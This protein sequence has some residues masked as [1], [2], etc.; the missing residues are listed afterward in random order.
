MRAIVVAVLATTLMGQQFYPFQ[1]DGDALSGAPDFSWLNKPLQPAD[2]VFVRDGHFYKLG[3][4]LVPDTED[5]ARIRF[6]GVNTTFGGN[7]PAEKDAVRIARRLRRLG[8]NLV[9]FHHMD[10]SPDVDP[11]SARSVLL[12]TG[13]YPTF[14]PVALERLRGFLRALKA[15]GIYANINLHVGYRFRPETDGVP[16]LPGAENLPTQSKPLHILYPRMVELQSDF[17]RELLRRLGVAGDPVLAMVETNNETSLLWHWQVNRLDEVLGGDYR[18]E[19]IRQ[20]NEYLSSRYGTTEALREAWSAGARSAGPELL[21]EP[22]RPLEVHSPADARLELQDDVAAVVVQRAGGPVILKK[23]GFSVEAAAAYSGEIEIRADLP[24]GESRTVYWDLKMDVEPWRTQAGRHLAVSNRWQQFTLPF[25]GAFTMDKVGRM[26]LSV[27]GAGAGTV[28]YV[29]NASLRQIGRYGLR[30]GE[31]LQKANIDLVFPGESVTEGRTTDFLLFLA[32]RDRAYHQSMLKAVRDVTD[33]LVPVAGTQMGFG[34]LMLVDAHLDLDYTDEHFYIDHY[35][36]PNAAWDGRDWRFRDISS[37]GSGL[38]TFLNVA[39]KRVGLQPYTVSEFNQPFP[40]TYAAEVDPTL[41]AFG[42]FQDWDAIMHFDYASSTNWDSGVPASF[43]LMN[44]QTK[45]P[46][47]GQSAYLFRSGAIAT[48]T[49][50][51]DLPVPESRRIEATRERRNSNV[52]GFLRE[53]YGYEPTVALE[54]RVQL[55]PDLNGPLPERAKVRADDPLVSETGQLR[56]SPDRKRFVVTA[57]TAAAVF[58]FVGTESVDADGFQ[59]QLAPSARG[60]TATLLTSLDGRPIRESTRL[61]VSHPGYTLRTQPGT[62][63]P[64]PQQIVGYLNSADWLTL[65]PE[66][67]SS[68][69]SGNLNGGPGPV[70]MERIEAT[71]TIRSCAKSM[72]VWPLNGRGE[73]LDRIEAAPIDGGFQIRLQSDGQAFSPWFEI[74]AEQ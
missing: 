45:L 37:L 51:L 38:S 33:T 18:S 40:N 60:F 11:N 10:S 63:P 24:D 31:L 1:V 48:G 14:N 35:N 59:I 74:D 73:R 29:R 34:G 23:V 54:R 55:R 65:E 12:A 22:W 4:D 41:A 5:D 42:A 25:T 30:D 46:G 69:P 53:R 15:E 13:P 57:D 6:F 49:E 50:V 70:W 2:R 39:T 17:S 47:I 71:L 62:N 28:V 36:F 64:R 26:G 27:E 66:L 3:P 72:A 16:S 7:F 58:G 61:L 20:W 43:T 56:Y 32:D 21:P 68:K 44:D 9:R 19:A 8:V 52:A 67:G